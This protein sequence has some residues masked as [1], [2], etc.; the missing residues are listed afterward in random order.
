MD[1]TKHKSVDR[2]S[3]VNNVDEAY[4]LF[5]QIVDRMWSVFPLREANNVLIDNTFALSSRLGYGNSV[6]TGSSIHSLWSDGKRCFFVDGAT[7]YEMDIAYNKTAIRTVTP[8]HRMSFCV[9]NDRYYYT[10]TQ[11]IGYIQ[12]ATSYDC[13]DPIREYKM[14][15]PA[16]SHIEYFMGCLFVSVKNVLYISDPL[17]DYFDTRTG[18]RIFTDDITMIRAVDNGLYI[19]D[20]KVW[21]I[22]GKGNDEFARVEVESDPA[23]PFTDLRTSADS[24]G[25]GVSGDVAVWTSKS[26]IVVGDSGGT[27]KNLTD[28]RYH[29]DEYG[30]GAAFVR[31]VNNVK[32]YINTLY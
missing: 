9:N 27:V 4:R 1:I 21:F 5:P 26:G 28:E 19:S 20:S 3:G 22:K 17:C 30:R 2:F 11:E 16:G 7:L 8:S 29:M 32:H 23:I 25:Y 6:L 31:N 18:Y 12:G 24:M 14:P 13:M 15:L 10:N